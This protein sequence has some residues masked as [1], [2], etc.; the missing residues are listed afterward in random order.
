M[1][2]ST[3]VVLPSLLVLLLFGLQGCGGG[4]FV[5]CP[6]GASKVDTSDGGFPGAEV[7]TT[8]LDFSEKM[9]WQAFSEDRL[10]QL[11]GTTV[12]V[13]FT[14]DWCLT[15]KVNEKTILETSAVRNG[16]ADLG[17]IPLKAD[18]T[19]RDQ[20]ITKWLRR[21]GKAGVPFAPFYL[22]VPADRSR[23]N[24][25]LPEVLTTDTVLAALRQA[26]G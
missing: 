4:M 3:S 10:S 24:I 7:L 2:F 20:V 9:P 14:A 6:E 17:V 12:F 23:D 8:D 18:W 21:Y 5:S 25:P 1:N 19:R 22:V 15:C 26:E 16:M 13:D 11:A